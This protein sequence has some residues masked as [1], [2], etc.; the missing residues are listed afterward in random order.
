MSKVFKTVNKARQSF[1]KFTNILYKQRAQ[2][3]K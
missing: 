2:Y 1:L 3:K